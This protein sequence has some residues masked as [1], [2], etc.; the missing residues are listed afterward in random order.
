[1][2]DN[3]D[4]LTAMAQDDGMCDV[5]ETTPFRCYPDADGQVDLY[6]ERIQQLYASHARKDV[7]LA[8]LRAEVDCVP[9]NQLE[10]EYSPHFITITF[11]MMDPDG[12]EAFENARQGAER[13]LVI[14][15]LLQEMRRVTRYGHGLFNA[16]IEVQHREGIVMATEHWCALIY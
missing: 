9:D 15:D 1:M 14:W 12:R 11:D 2:P 3:T 6:K 7:E 5:D 10:M 8:R 4:E 13:G 16:A